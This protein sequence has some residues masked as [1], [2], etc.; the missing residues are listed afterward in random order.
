[1]HT[2]VAHLQSQLRE[3]QRNPVGGFAVE[4]ENNDLFKWRVYFAGSEGTHYHPGIYRATLTFPQ[5]F[6]FKPPVLTINS[7]F[8]H[9]NVYNEGDSSHHSG[10]VC[11]SIL[12]QPGTDAMNELE[13][14][15]MRYSPVVTI[16]KILVSFISLLADPDPAE[17]GA[18]ANVDALAM[19]R[20][21][22]AKYVRI[23]TENAKRSLQELPDG[24][25]MPQPKD[26]SKPAVSIF[27]GMGAASSTDGFEYDYSGGGGVGNGSGLGKP[28][29][30]ASGSPSSK[31]A[32]TAAGGAR[33]FS[34][35]LARVKHICPDPPKSDADLLKMLE[36]YK[37]DVDRVV[38]DMW[39]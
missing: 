17:A 19:Y 27:S 33:D 13:T 11:M 23:C 15:S 16:E 7:K 22:K 21:D 34:T 5:E 1:M 2:A 30:A 12:H 31:A 9:P 14:A 39:D 4:A 38:V 29:A 6:P 24:F 32:A 28:A 8:W 25:S 3:L 18:P 20:R 10:E 35:E 36:K 26:M 37:G